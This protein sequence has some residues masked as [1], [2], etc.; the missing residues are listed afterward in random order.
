MSHQPSYTTTSFALPPARHAPESEPQAPVRRRPG[1]P[2]RQAPPAPSLPSAIHPAYKPNL[3]QVDA[4]NFARLAQQVQSQQATIS[5]L[6]TRIEILEAARF[7]FSVQAQAQ[8]QA[9]AGIVASASTRTAQNDTINGSNQ[10][11]DEAGSSGD[12]EEDQ[13][14]DTNSPLQQLLTEINS[15]QQPSAYW[16]PAD[17]TNPVPPADQEQ[18]MAYPPEGQRFAFELTVDPA[19]G[20]RWIGG[21][22]QGASAVLNAWTGPHGYRIHTRRSKVKSGRY[23]L[24]ICCAW[25]GEKSRPRKIAPTEED[26]ENARQ[27]GRR[28]PYERRPLADGEVSHDCPFRFVMRQV[29]KGNKLFE[30]Q[31]M[32]T[33]GVSLPHNHG[34]DPNAMV[35]RRPRKP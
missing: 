19:S 10:N 3:I 11:D 15:S 33:R 34:P 30:V 16:A 7:A 20:R 29:E 32:K 28:K 12:E 9:R 31:F 13:D 22:S 17:W 6:V 14:S 8:P 26:V 5:S 24:T 4:E 21:G 27:E 1:R 35:V 18:D 2:P 23:H 25:S